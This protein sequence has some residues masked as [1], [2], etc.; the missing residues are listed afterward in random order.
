MLLVPLWIL[1]PSSDFIF[2]NKFTTRL[3]TLTSLL[4]LARHLVIWAL[5]HMVGIAENVRH[6]MTYK[7]L[8]VNTQKIIYHSNLYSASSAD[9]N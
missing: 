2:G 1:A 4:N 7:V 5:G 8:T 3:M 9:P 6:A